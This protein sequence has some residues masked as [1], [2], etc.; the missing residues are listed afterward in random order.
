MTLNKIK[1][2]NIYLH[3]HVNY[4][5]KSTQTKYNF[6]IKVNYSK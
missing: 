4:F 3:V 5:S 6:T 2:L 1:G